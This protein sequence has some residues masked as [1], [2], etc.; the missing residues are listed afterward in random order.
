MLSLLEG[1]AGI[2]KRVDGGLD[3]VMVEVDGGSF[4]DFRYICKEIK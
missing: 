3:R 2:W 1:I 4:V